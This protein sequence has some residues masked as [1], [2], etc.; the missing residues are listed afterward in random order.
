MYSKLRRSNGGYQHCLR[1]ARAEQFG[2]L[3]SHSIST[4]KKRFN[5]YSIVLLNSWCLMIENVKFT[6]AVSDTVFDMMNAVYR[7]AFD[8]YLG[9]VSGE[10]CLPSLNIAIEMYSLPVAC[11]GK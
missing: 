4:G 6:K 2:L 1:I 10:A 8:V 7:Q 5:F 11:F 3:L 9:Y